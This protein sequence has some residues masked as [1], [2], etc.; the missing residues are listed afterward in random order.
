VEAVSAP[1]LQLQSVEKSFTG[2]RALKSVSFDLEAGETC[3]FIGENGAG[4]STLIKI[5]SGT[6]P[7]SGNIIWQGTRIQFASPHDAM[8][9]GI[10]TI[11]QNWLTADI[12]RSR[13]ICSSASRGRVI[14]GVA[15]TGTDC[16]ARP[17]RNSPGLI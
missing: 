7:D 1:L 5:L 2:V 16:I 4:K 13:R 11:H 10:A 6:P 9:A 14:A 17:K 3:G 8:A 15:S 12:S